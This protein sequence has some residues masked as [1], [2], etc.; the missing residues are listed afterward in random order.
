MKRLYR[1]KT[2]GILAIVLSVFFISCMYIQDDKILKDNSELSK[3]VNLN[4]FIKG[5]KK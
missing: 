2:V 1:K 4:N 5:Q 3:F